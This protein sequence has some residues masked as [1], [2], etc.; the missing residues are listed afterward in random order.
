MN[1]FIL[2]TLVTWGVDARVNSRAEHYPA[3]YTDES[4][5]HPYLDNTLDCKHPLY[6]NCRY[7]TYDHLCCGPD[8]YCCN[9]NTACC[10]KSVWTIYEK[11]GVATGA[12]SWF[13]III[14]LGICL[15]THGV[16]KAIRYCRRKRKVSPQHDIKVHFVSKT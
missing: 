5:W 9:D 1:I 14:V 10:R 3:C 2:L 4:Y 11:V 6:T 8:H 16:K 12:L 7:N 13:G 15:G